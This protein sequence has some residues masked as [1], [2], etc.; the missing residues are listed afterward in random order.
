MTY[1]ISAPPGVRLGFS[2]SQATRDLVRRLKFPVNS[3]FLCMGF[4]KTRNPCGF[5]SAR[6]KIPCYFPCYWGIS[7]SETATTRKSAALHRLATQHL[8]FLP[9]SKKTWGDTGF[10]NQG[11]WL[12][13]FCC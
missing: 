6:K 11:C 3:L 12:P 4:A 2:D 13:F 1:R 9:A 7:H 10:K 8:S 5:L